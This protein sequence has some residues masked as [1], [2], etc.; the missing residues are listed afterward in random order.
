MYFFVL[1][2]V[3]FKISVNAKRPMSKQT[4]L[5]SYVVDAN[6]ITITIK[7]V[8]LASIQDILTVFEIF[9]LLRFIKLL[10]IFWDA[11]YIHSLRVYF[12]RTRKERKR[13]GQ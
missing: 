13:E 12:M 3:A 2:T 10:H 5:S 11:R 7:V 4:F 9:V 8:F 1:F 6:K